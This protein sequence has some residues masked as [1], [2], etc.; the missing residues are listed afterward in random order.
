M[1]SSIVIS[2]VFVVL[3]LC[4]VCRSNRRSGAS[5][6]SG[7]VSSASRNSAGRRHMRGMGVVG[8]N[9]RHSSTGIGPGVGQGIGGKNSHQN[10]SEGQRADHNSMS[11]YEVS[12]HCS[13]CE[14]IHLFTYVNAEYKRTLS[15]YPCSVSHFCANQ[16]RLG[17]TVRNFKL[18]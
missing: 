13:L 15:R 4:C 18:S 16:L 8:G 7:L 9:H 17:F 3:I 10:Y 2:A 14:L 12:P 5:G 11:D 1:T 6:G